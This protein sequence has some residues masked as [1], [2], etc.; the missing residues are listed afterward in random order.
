MRAAA[1]IGLMIITMTT[2]SAQNKIV[3]DGQLSS[4]GSYA[5]QN[6]LEFLLGGRYIPELTYGIPLDSANKLDFMA[7][8]NIFGSTSFSGDSSY[9][10]GDVQAYRV[11]GRF[12]G[13]QYELRIGLQ[14]IDFGAAQILRPMQW[15]NQVDPRDP[16]SIT[17]GVTGVLGRY[18]FLNNANIW[19]WGLYGNKERKGYELIASNNKVPEFGGRVQMPIPRGEFGLSYHHRTAD[20]RGVSPIFPEFEK[21]PENRIGFDVK[22]DVIVGFWLEGSHITKSENLGI[23]TN[24]T[25]LNAGF[26]YTIGLGSGINFVTEHLIGTADEEA[27]GFTNTSNTTAVSMSYPITFFD[28]VSM[29]STYSWDTEDFSFFFNYEHQFKRI[30]GYVMAFYNPDR[31]PGLIENEIE[32]T[33]RGPGFRLMLV[34]NH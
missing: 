7:S 6:D 8:A 23:L 2:L 9:N 34:Y 4:Y 33:L 29:F 14:K 1:T 28:N 18:Y 5:W 11:W 24:Q 22:W 17:R 31:P 32:Y 10:I 19:V 30:A 26:D 3:F 16:L 15:F 25:L 27:L 12:V 13:E 21:I 20:S